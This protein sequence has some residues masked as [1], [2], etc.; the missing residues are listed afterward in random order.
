MRTVCGTAAGD[1]VVSPVPRLAPNTTVWSRTVGTRQ[2]AA[3]GNRLRRRMNPKLVYVVTV[4]QSFVLLRGQARYMQAEGFEVSGVSS[5]GP[6]TTVFESEEGVSVTLIEMPRR[7]SPLADLV[8]LTRL[9]RHLRRIRPTIVHAH[10]PKGGLLGMISSWVARVPVRVYH[11][12]GLPLETSSGLRKALLAIS[13]RVSCQLAHRVLAVS[14]GV[15][16]KSIDAG[17][18]SA[19]K[20]FVPEH[21]SING[22]DAVNEFGPRISDAENRRALHAAWRIDEGALVIAF[23]G[24]IVRDKGVG[25]L[26]AAWAQIRGAY[27]STVLVLAGPEE[28]RDPVPQAVR[29]ELRRDPRVRMLGLV[30]QPREVYLSA[31]IVVLPTYREGLPGVPLE[32]AAMG[33]PVVITN[34]TGCEEAVEDG[35]TATVVPIGDVGALANALRAYLDNP[36]LRAAHGASGRARVLERFAPPRLW[37]AHS[38][39]YMELLRTR[40]PIEY[41]H[42]VAQRQRALPRP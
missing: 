21:G 20:V 13:E 4:P 42:L 1:A 26:A 39:V 25:E 35:V 29:D 23:V 14:R 19:A 24:R 2:S 41:E 22:V 11:V 36:E 17:L 10:T 37:R 32:A 30:D 31:D 28:E 6:W 9:V 3:R 8:A 27:P 7:I 5:P 12:H 33:L 38:D 34:A 40:R 15:R 18:V 16:Q